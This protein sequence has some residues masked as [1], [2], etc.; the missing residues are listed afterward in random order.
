MR[1]DPLLL[2]TCAFL[3][4]ALGEPIAKRV[5]VELENAAR[6]GRAYLSPLSVQET[7]RLAEKR[8]L[9]LRPT[10]FSWMQRALRKMHLAEAAFTWD[11]AWEAGGFYDINGDP[12]D[13][14]L[15]GTALAGGFTL[16]TRDDDLLD[17]ARRKGVR[18]LDTWGA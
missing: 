5:L 15:L 14:G 13:R 3:D 10:P 9:E 1:D 16:V 2:D 6:E 4:W 8:K 18:A 7:L 12:V 11:A 17:G